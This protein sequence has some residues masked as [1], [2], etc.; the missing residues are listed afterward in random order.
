MWLGKKQ[1]WIFQ[2]TG[3]GSF[4]LVHLFFNWSLGKIQTGNDRSLFFSKIG[5]FIALGLVLT[6][7]MRFLLS[8]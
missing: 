7:I 8:G 4:I 1:Y 3:W 2:V 5:I 6:H